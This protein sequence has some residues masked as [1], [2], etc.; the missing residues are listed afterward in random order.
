MTCL[1]KNASLPVTLKTREYEVF[2][3]VPLKKLD[4][5]VSF[6]AVGL[7]GMF[8]SGGAVTAVRYV[9]DAGVEVRVRGSGTVGA[10]SSAKP[11]RV[12][13]DLEAAEFS[14]DDGCGLVTFELAVPEQELYSWTISIEY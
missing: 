13:V 12:V 5:G 2:T 14:Y 9:E 6:A 8:N 10:Y 7:I 11:A 1:P 3:V 4:N